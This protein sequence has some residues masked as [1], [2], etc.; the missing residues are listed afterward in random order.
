MATYT[1]KHYRRLFFTSPSETLLTNEKFCA[2]TLL[3]ALAAKEERLTAFQQDS[4]YAE[5]LDDTKTVIWK[6]SDNTWRP[7]A[8][9][10]H[11]A[12]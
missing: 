1:L 6:S 10:W 9:L 2:D 3:D 7:Y 4:D 12:F 8:C 11:K 5:L